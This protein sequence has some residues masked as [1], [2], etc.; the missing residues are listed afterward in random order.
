MVGRRLQV[1][2]WF[3]VGLLGPALLC[4]I[5]LWTYGLLTQD[6]EQS[7]TASSD[8]VPPTSRQSPSEL[9][10]GQ[11]NN[12][13]QDLANLPP[14]TDDYTRMVAL[15]ALLS[16]SDE[17]RVI[18][19]LE[20]SRQIRPEDRRLATR[21]EIF[22]RFAVIDPVEAMKHTVDIAWNRR[23]P[24][25]NAIFL[26]WATS[27]VDA[28]I[29]HAKTLSSADQR[30]ALGAILRIQGDWSDDRIQALASEFGLES[31]SAETLDQI[32]VARAFSD[33]RA[34]WHALL[35][36]NRN[37]NVQIQS[38]ATILELWVDREGF[39]VVFE[40]MESISYLEYTSSILDPILTPIAQEDPHLAFELIQKFDENA[41][42]NASFIVVGEWAAIDPVAAFETVSEFDF[43]PTYVKEN[44]LQNIGNAWARDDP[45]EAIQEL[46]KYLS[47][48][49]LQWVRGY[50]LAEI[51]RKS[52]QDAL[53]VLNEIPNGVEELGEAFV[54]EWA[55]SDARSALNWIRLQDETLRPNLLENAI[56]GLIELD[57]ELALNAAL[58]QK[59]AEG[60]LG[61]E[62][63][64]IRI[65]AQTDVDRATEML[66]QVRDHEATRKRAFSE[67]GRALAY[68]NRSSA[69]IEL[70]SKLPESF[71][72][73][74]FREIINAIYNS[75]QV[76][77][78]EILNLLPKPKYQ[79]EAARY[80][81]WDRGLGGD[82]HRYFTDEQLEKIQAYQ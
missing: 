38:L 57:P 43:R 18:S 12:F 65:L 28:A 81:I 27:D 76:E 45:Y 70:G 52:P 51:V 44:L 68:K 72:D 58:N 3:C 36:D 11:K 48:H 20:Q 54:R 5:G 78:Y 41:R 73:E 34:S 30:T 35:E 22:R 61:L 26:E 59:I 60:Q 80:L 74:Y 79:Q 6:D 53:D 13:P 10:S 8:D 31:I 39:D 24:I 69:A 21:I 4:G 29:A 7:S 1:I 32:Q 47:S 82:S 9:N 49:N 25:V 67:L 42:R 46:P 50:A 75:D 63:E 17:E 2:T 71:Q 23:A 33:P 56:P 77:L 37:E 64:V 19:L 16:S 55:S 15:R 40:A 62:Y 14:I 66:P